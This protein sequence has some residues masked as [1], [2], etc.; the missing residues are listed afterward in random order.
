MQRL[1]TEAYAEFEFEEP[2]KVPGSEYV[3]RCPK[4]T[5]KQSRGASTGAEAPQPEQRRLN[6]I[7]GAS[8]ESEAP[9]PEQR[10]LNQSKQSRGV[11]TA[12]GIPHKSSQGVST[13]EGIIHKQIPGTEG[14]SGSHQAKACQPLRASF[15]SRSAPKA[16]HIK[17]RRVNR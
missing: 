3:K 7:G 10:C 2:A 14:R 15:T 1:L 11:S 16:V 17:P 5:D 6:R 8:T 13:A 12:E 9:Q 4:E